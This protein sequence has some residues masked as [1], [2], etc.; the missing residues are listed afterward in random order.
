M[1]SRNKTLMV[2]LV[3]AGLRRALPAQAQSEQ[4]GVELRQR[5]GAL[6]AGLHELGGV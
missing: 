1:E 3:S 2:T 5:E 6:D 4:V